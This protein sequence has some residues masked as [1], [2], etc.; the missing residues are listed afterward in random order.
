[1]KL[2][3]AKKKSPKIVISGYYG[4]DNCGD[5]AVLMS[6]I[7]C[8]KTLMPD[9]GIVVLSANPRKTRDLYGVKAVNRWNP[10]IIA[11]AILSCNLFISGGGSLLQD[12]TGT[13]SVKYYLG[14]IRI[15]LL[16]R[17]NVM[18]YGQG[19]GP[20]SGGESRANV[21]KV[22]NRCKAISVR[23]AHSAKLL[24]EL[25][26]K[27][28]VRVTCDPVMALRVDDTELLNI[29]AE[30][31]EL[32]LPI[33]ASDAKKPLLLA[34][35]RSWS[36][37]RHIAR[38]AE[39]LD[40][41]IEQ[42]WDVLLVPAHFIPDSE[43]M[44]QIAEEMEHRPY[45]LDKCLTARQFLTLT[46]RADKVFSMRLHGLIC[47]MA[48]GTPMFA[49]SYDPKVGAFMEQ[50]EMNDFCLSFE[51]FESNEATRLL[52]ELD[53]ISARKSQ[54]LQARRFDMHNLAWE[55]AQIAAD[56]L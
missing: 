9:V 25:G 52:D 3:K 30:L 47:A 55:T 44:I 12:V 11:L 27:R 10:L 19:V 39:I 17:K 16:L 18:I 35:V 34:S 1:M 24:S 2:L 26:V 48:V 20:L 38:I 43:T 45:C 50:A 31:E 29:E 33:D 23:D 42:G 51:N 32:G 37:N 53:A 5:E 41:Q 36:D 28:D 15:A 21:A 46:A 54:G 7:H 4:F 8:L 40:V 49:L 22:L 56:M 14:V 6:M 13:G